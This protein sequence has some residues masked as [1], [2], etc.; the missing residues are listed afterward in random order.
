[1]GVKNRRLR[2]KILNDFLDNERCNHPT[3]NPHQIHHPNHYS[4]KTCQVTHN[5]PQTHDKIRIN[6]MMAHTPS[7]ELGNFF[8]NFNHPQFQ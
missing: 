3:N 6:K 2:R 5:Y 7:L 1:M 4:H 8:T